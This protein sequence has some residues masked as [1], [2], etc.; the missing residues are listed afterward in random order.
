MSSGLMK[1]LGVDNDR[2]KENPPNSL[3]R[4]FFVDFD[5]IIEKKY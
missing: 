4:R 2:K 5:I 3:V 1:E